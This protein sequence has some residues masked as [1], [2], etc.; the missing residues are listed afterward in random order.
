MRVMI[1][2]K[3]ALVVS[4]PA[5][6]ASASPGSSMSSAL[7]TIRLS[8]GRVR[9][10][11]A[12]PSSFSRPCIGRISGHA[13]AGKCGNRGCP[14]GVLLLQQPPYRR[15]TPLAVLVIDDLEA[16]EE[17][18][19]G[20]PDAVGAH[21]GLLHAAEGHVPLAHRAVVDVDHA[22]LRAPHE[23]PGE[24]HVVGEDGRGQPVADLVVY[25]EGLRKVFYGRHHEHRAEDLVQ[26]RGR[27][28]LDIG[29]YRRLVV[30]ALIERFAGRLLA[31]EDDAGPVLLG[32]IDVMYGPLE[33]VTAGE[34]AHGRSVVEAVSNL[35]LLSLLDE[36][37]LELFLLLLENDHAANRRAALPR[38]L[39]SGC[40]DLRRRVLYVAEPRDHAA[41]LAT[42]L[43]LHLL[44][45]RRGLLVDAEPYVGRAGEG[46]TAHARVGD[47]GVPDLPTAADDEVDDP[48]GNPSFLEHLDDDHRGQR[49]R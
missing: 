45:G 25:P 36:G 26:R 9:T 4:P 18:L 39:V 10:V 1:S 17:L 35:E 8:P 41:V 30:V 32:E 44:V 43:E 47:E 19:V 7:W 28:R 13:W 34:R 38:R 6:T 22:G 11:N 21:A 33:L 31:P 5:S 42:H 24:V 27:S 29:Q 14:C 37:C 48:R 16:G 46:N 3:M 12:E 49:R 23:R 40:D 15:P 20:R 2:P